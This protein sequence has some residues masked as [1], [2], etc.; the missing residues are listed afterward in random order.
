MSELSSS[1]SPVVVNEPFRAYVK[2][3]LQ[4]LGSREPL[5]VLAETPEALRQAV[6]GLS[7]EQDGAP[8]RPGKWSVRQVVQHL[9]DSELVGAFRF[10]MVLAHDAP[11]LPAYDQDLWADRLRY[12][13]ADL[14]TA[15]DDFAAL[16]ALNLRVLRRAT[17]DELENRVMR[18]AERGDEPLGYMASLY[19]GHDLVHLAQIRRIRQ[20]IGAPAAG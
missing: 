16:R 9:A 18:H 3:L 5:A 20:A 7:R 4:A 13:E 2:S 15:L 14:A 19:A 1:A 11:E 6:A 12:Q 10:R 8:E 17:P